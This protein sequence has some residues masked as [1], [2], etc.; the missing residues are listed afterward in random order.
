MRPFTIGSCLAIWPAR[1]QPT[2]PE[3]MVGSFG[4]GLKL[5]LSESDAQ[6][7]APYR[8]PSNATMLNIWQQHFADAEAISY[9]TTG[10]VVELPRADRSVFLA[11]VHNLPARFSNSS[12]GFYTLVLNVSALLSGITN[13]RTLLIIYPQAYISMY[14]ACTPFSTAAI[15]QGLPSLTGSTQPLTL[16]S[17]AKP[18]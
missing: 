15:C 2:P 13:P 18:L 6:G 5:A 10:I 4:M 7:L 9:I 16:A 8:I 14:N 17:V 1:N 3:I 11:R 12:Q